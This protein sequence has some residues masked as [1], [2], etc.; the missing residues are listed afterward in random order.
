MVMIEASTAHSGVPARLVPLW[1]W[2]SH[3]RNGAIVWHQV[4][5]A[6]CFGTALANHNK[7][8]KSQRWVIHLRVGTLKTVEALRTAQKVTQRTPKARSRPKPTQRELKKR[9]GQPLPESR[10]FASQSRKRHS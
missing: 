7:A 3:A 8:P 9:E 10:L 6:F 4:Y 5:G 1:V 2:H